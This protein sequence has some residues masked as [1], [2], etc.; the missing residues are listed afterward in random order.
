[1]SLFVTG[2]DGAVGSYVA[3]IFS[4]ERLFLTDV[5]NL[6]ITDREAMRRALIESKAKTVL[7]LAAET[8]VDRC[9]AEPEHAYR[10]NALGCENVALACREAGAR[11]VY[12]STGAVFDGR[13]PEPCTEFD[14]PAPVNVYARAKLAGEEAVRRLVPEHFIVR[15]G[16]MIG[17]GRRDKKFVYKIL[18]LM[19]EREEISAVSDKRGTLT[20]A[21][22][23]LLQVK[24]YLADGR[25]G[26][27][28]GAHGGVVTRFDV[29]LELARLTGKKVK[30]KA[31]GSDAFPLP[32]PRGDSEAIRNYKAQLLGIDVMPDW[33]S[34]LAAYVRELEA[35]GVLKDGKVQDI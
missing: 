10:V 3:D 34:A 32:A 21:R 14:A 35:V 19:D 26:T 9:E 6:D 24:A 12:I 25:P 20:Y 1:M 17:G 13:N 7:H 4:Q 5:K 27:Y 18:R 31:V 29:A 30:V 22:D 15:A 2:A 16:W 11:L 28:H 23:L 33:K 8:N